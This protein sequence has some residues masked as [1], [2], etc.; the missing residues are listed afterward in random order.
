MTRI[1]LHLA[2]MLCAVPMAWAT[3][4]SAGVS[5]QVVVRVVARH[6]LA[7]GDNVGGAMVTIR[8]AANGAVLASGRQTGPSGDVRIIVQTPR[9]HSEPVYSL[10]ESASFTAELSLSKP[11]LV[12][13]IAE[14][15][16][17][18][19][20]AKRRASKTV[21]L[22]PGRPVS[23]D[24]IV[25]ELEGLLVK[26]EAPTTE[27]PLGIG[28][29]GTLGAT[30]KMLCGCIVEPFGNW[31]SRKMDLYGE[32]RRGDTV[33]QKIDLYHQGPKG[34]FTGNFKIP[35]ALNGEKLISLRVV[36]SDAEAVN[37][38]FDEVSYPLVPWEESRDA[39]G[40]EI[41]AIIQPA[42]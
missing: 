9:L 24:G 36:A 33:I 40:R 25:I 31:D 22:Y 17:N 20:D 26:I 3:D 21:L 19:P 8:D 42:K 14:G 6:A 15:P 41:P 16:L 13:I 28:D 2:L 5:T 38:G 30:V 18:F 39:T 10:R 32:L 23:G 1:F 29:E 34:L 27:R 4:S 35:R 37:V 12:E 7:L 11:T